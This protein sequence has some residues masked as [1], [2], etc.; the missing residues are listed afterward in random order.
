[1]KVNGAKIK[2]FR[3]SQGWS[4]SDLAARFDPIVTRQAVESWE[5]NGIGGFKLLGRVAKALGIPPALLIE[6]SNGD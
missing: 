3:E 6:S 1:M 5:K 2:E 4:T